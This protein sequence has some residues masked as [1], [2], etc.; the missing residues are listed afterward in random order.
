VFSG[1]R[2]GRAGG[3]MAFDNHIEGS[4]TKRYS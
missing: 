4:S 3:K 2:S 1:L